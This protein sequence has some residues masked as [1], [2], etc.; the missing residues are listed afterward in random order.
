MSATEHYDAIVLGTGEAGKY[1]GWHL[2]AQGQR[3]AAIEKDDIGGACPNVA[4]LPSKN[5]IHSAKVASYFQ[6]GEEFGVVHGEW[7]VDMSGVRSRRQ[8]MIDGLHELHLANFSKSGAEIVL[9]FGRFVGERTLQV[10]LGAGGQRILRAER[11]FVDTGSRA[12]LEPLPGLAAAK[13]LSHVEALQLD[14]VPEHLIIVG[15]GYVGL[16]FAQA[17]R[18]FG[19][20]VTIVERNPRLAHREDS[21]VS[22]AL[23]QLFHDER[24]DVLTSTRITRIEGVSGVEVALHLTQ[25]SGGSVLEGSHLLIAAG[26]TPNTQHMGLELGGIRTTSSGHIQV[27]DRLE[28]TAPNV[29][30]M[31]D[32]AGSPHFTHISFDDFRIIRDNLAG[33][34]RSTAGR[35]VPSCMFTDPELA[36][37]GLTE[38]EAT[39][40]GITYRLAKIPMLAVLR[41]RTLSESRGFLK[42]LVSTQNDAILGFT[43][44]GTGVGELLAPVQLAMAAGLPYTA[45]RA[46]IIAHPTL[47]EGLVS[48][49]SAIPP[50]P[51]RQAA[52]PTRPSRPIESESPQ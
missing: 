39:R 47:A 17:M 12:T 41:T 30:A 49:F 1:M 4:C 31:G 15:G 40:Q 23:Q 50:L 35:Q 22:E 24:I 8:R 38:A 20:R 18:R 34:K 33:A 37:V 5:I 11:V 46:L 7:H 45:V 28:T 21:D 44:F 9:G 2:A 13:P 42:A 26:R 10:D 43:A 3:V 48:L 51:S 32:C 52:S 29:W 27:N 36:H 14:V 25:T 19:A 6:R 16:E